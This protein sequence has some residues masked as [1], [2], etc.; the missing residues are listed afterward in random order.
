MAI[1]D[2]VPWNKSGS[3]NKRQALRKVPSCTAAGA[4][5]MGL[6]VQVPNAR[7]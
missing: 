7:S 4:R 5:A 6:Q 2:L 3:R 1:R